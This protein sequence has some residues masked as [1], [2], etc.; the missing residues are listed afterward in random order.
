M[1]EESQIP[2]DTDP[3]NAISETAQ[4]TP[5]EADIDA[6]DDPAEG[7]ESDEEG[8]EEDE[9][10]LTPLDKDTGADLDADALSGQDDDREYDVSETI[11]KT[12]GM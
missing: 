4:I 8:L 10:D 7:E 3:A 1:T 2:A 12:T 9:D 6:E 11:E 5:G